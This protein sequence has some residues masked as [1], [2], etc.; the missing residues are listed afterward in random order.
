MKNSFYN[1]VSTWL[2]LIGILEMFTA[3]IWATI[4]IID[5]EYGATLIYAVALGTTGLL[6]TSV[7]QIMNA[8]SRL[9]DGVN[10]EK[11]SA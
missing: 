1:F 7:G 10:S 6:V 4:C 3:I 11:K 5:N 8:L 2:N 9:V